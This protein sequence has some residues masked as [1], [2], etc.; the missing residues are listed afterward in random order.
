VSS[1][2]PCFRANPEEVSVAVRNRRARLALALMVGSAVVVLAAA[3]GGSDSGGKDGD[4]QAGGEAGGFAAYAS[5]LKKQGIDVP[6]D[7]PTGRPR[8]SGSG[9]PSGFPSGR[10]SGWPSGR[11]SVRPSGAPSPGASGRF[12]GG[13]RGGF[14]GLRPEGVD[15]ATWQKAQ[16]ACQSVLP[17]GGPGRSR[18]PDGAGRNGGGQGSNPAYANCLSDHG[19]PRGS[20]LST[21]DPKV[22]AA[23]QACSVLSPAPAPAAS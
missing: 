13:Q 20:G 5:C 4:A 18:G 17:T 2:G 23:L 22:A 21:A 10:P 16:Q 12:G 15:D 11:P 1:P 7:L 8:P 6:D 14:G 19:V 3:C 9:R